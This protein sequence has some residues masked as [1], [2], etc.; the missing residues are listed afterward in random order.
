[1]FLRSSSFQSFTA[2]AICCAI[3]I[4]SAKQKTRIAG[5]CVSSTECSDHS[6]KKV[7]KVRCDK[8]I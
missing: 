7:Y 1:M 3:S 8:K 6:L 5:Y 2:V 4:E